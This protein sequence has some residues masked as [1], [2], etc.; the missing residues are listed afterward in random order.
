MENFVTSG[1]YFEFL[2]F[3]SGLSVLVER[4]FGFLRFSAAFFAAVSFPLE[5]HETSHS[6]RPGVFGL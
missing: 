3:D 6:A 2:F 1:L 5:I 4:N